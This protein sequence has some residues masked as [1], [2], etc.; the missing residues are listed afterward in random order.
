MPEEMSNIEGESHI[1][2]PEGSQRE[3]QKPFQPS[4]VMETPDEFANL[5]PRLQ[6]R[7]KQLHK[8]PSAVVTPN[9]LRKHYQEIED[10]V[11]KG[12]VSEEEADPLMA[13][14]VS[15]IELLETSRDTSGGLRGRGPGP[16]EAAMRDFTVQIGN[17]IKTLERSGQLQPSLTPEQVAQISTAQAMAVEQQRTESLRGIFGRL[18]PD[19]EMSRWVDVEYDQEF[20]TKFTP[21]M[22]PNFYTALGTEQRKIWDAR[23]RLARAAYVKKVLSAQPEKLAENQDLIELTKEQ[24]EVLYRIPGVKF[25]LEWYALAIVAPNGEHKVGGK[26][27]LKCKS[28]A[29]FEAFRKLLRNK[30]KTLPEF[31]I[32]QDEEEMNLEDRAKV[33]SADAIAWNWI[34]CSNLVESIDSRYSLVDINGTKHKGEGRNGNLAPAVCSDDLRAVFHPQEKFED[35]CRKKQEWGNFGKWGL[36]QLQRINGEFGEERR[37]HIAFDEAARMLEDFWRARP[38]KVEEDGKIKE[39]IIVKAPECYPTTSMKSFW[40]SFDDGGEH[41]SLLDR[42]LNNQDIN[43]SEVQADPWK[44]SY[45][46]IKLRKAVGLFEIFTKESKEG[47]ARALLDIY[48]RLGTRG[49]LKDYYYNSNPPVLDDLSGLSD[50]AEKDRREEENKKR[51]KKAKDRAEDLTKKHFHN[52]K[53]W[54]V[55]AVQ[56]GVGRPQDKGVT[57]P[58]SRSRLE[59]SHRW[60]RS[61]HEVILRKPWIGY[62]ED[63]GLFKRESLVIESIE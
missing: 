30:M 32:Q 28:G 58:Y 50:G 18:P 41:T 16:I 21:N 43:W 23:W 56:G 55:Y 54:A 5:D 36:T 24:M 62:L 19:L 49:I 3:A 38:G 52:L 27:V 8:A 57:D 59:A 40:E 48:T 12:D 15:R 31:N 39:G 26:T 47:W 6:L 7:A 25:A 60:N 1:N 37:D 42:L 45:L 17:L 46:T 61:T 2:P 63:K 22:E 51:L 11:L 35:K 9:Y 33:V 34:W 53:V 4:W 10:Q 44:T 14:I 13:K 29:D 20:Y